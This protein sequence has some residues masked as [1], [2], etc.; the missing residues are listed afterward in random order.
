M[1]SSDV[2]FFEN[3]FVKKNTENIWANKQ[4]VVSY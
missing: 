3:P 4:N 1:A 2:L